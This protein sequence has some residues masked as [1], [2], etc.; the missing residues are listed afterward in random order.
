MSKAMIRLNAHPERYNGLRIENCGLLFLGTPHSGTVQ[1]DW[2][3]FI[4]GL[5]AVG[6]IRTELLKELKS[7]NEFSVESK[8]G[9]ASIAAKPPYFCIHETRMVK[10][11]GTHRYV[12]SFQI[13]FHCYRL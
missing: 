7:F 2:N 3:A 10:V 12:S 5:L 6:G 9:F 11:A 4:D 13:Y 8:D 1:A